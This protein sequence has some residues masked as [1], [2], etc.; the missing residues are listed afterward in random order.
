[1]QRNL[2]KD[3]MRKLGYLFILPAFFLLSCGGTGNGQGSSTTGQAASQKTDGG[4]GKAAVAQGKLEH[5]TAQTFKQKVMDYEK[6]PQTWVFEGD[7]PAIVDFYADWCKPC[8]MIAPILEEL[9]EEYDGKI[10]VYKVDTEAQRELASVFGIQS[11]PT[12]LFIP[13][14]GKPTMQKGA[15]SKEAYKQII[16]DFMLKK[17]TGSTN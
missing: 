2:I 13:M 3:N 1:M 16:D 7:K 9:A 12:V 4:S 8:R 6:N 14:E 15:M 5:L 10:T 11:L 17:A